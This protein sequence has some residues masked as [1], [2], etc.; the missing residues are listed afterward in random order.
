[1]TIGAHNACSMCTCLQHTK[2]D[3]IT[4]AR[5]RQAEAERELTLRTQVC[6][7]IIALAPCVIIHVGNACSGGCEEQAQV[8]L[9]SGAHPPARQPRAA[10]YVDLISFQS[11]SRLLCLGTFSARETIQDIAQFLQLFLVN[12]A[13]EFS[14]VQPGSANKLE[15]WTRTLL[16]ADLV[17]SSLIACTQAG[18]E[19]IVLKPKL[20]DEHRHK[21][22]HET[23]HENFTQNC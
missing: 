14:F 18:P 13:A 19:P 4:E 22:H 1:M 16:D 17:P 3:V 11:D 20:V 12:E 2:D 6:A 21:A 10:R 23:S 7:S 8:P 15:P 5:I 9:R